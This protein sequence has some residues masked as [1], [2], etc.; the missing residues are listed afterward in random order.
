MNPRFNVKIPDELKQD[1]INFSLCDNNE[2]Y[3]NVNRSNDLYH[4][5]R[6]CVIS[7]HPHLLLCKNIEQFS[8]QAY[9]EIGV[10]NFI[11]EHIYGNFIGVNLHDG[12]VHLHRDPRNDKGFIHPRF[13]FLVQKPEQGGE[14]VIDDV[15]YPMEEGQ[16]WINLASEWL[17]GSTPVV[18]AR[19]R[20]VLSLGAYVHPGVIRYLQ[21]KM[22]NGV[23]T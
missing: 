21:D 4:R 23:C 5:R 11:P 7:N 17:H 14:P 6:Y 13:N 15:L 18:G 22:E 10:D 9:A 20:I 1:I 2:V 3:F 19:A 12:N 8:K 16:A